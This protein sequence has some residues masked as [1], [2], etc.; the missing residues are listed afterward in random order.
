MSSQLDSQALKHNSE[1]TAALICVIKLYVH[2]S[3]NNGSDHEERK[4]K[5][6]KTQKLILNKHT[7]PCNEHEG[8][9]SMY[10]G[11]AVL[12]RLPSGF[13]RVHLLR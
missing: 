11:L 9:L 7:S 4:A 13:G 10:F 5:R 8:L 1:N 12:S 2:F 6:K 3:Q